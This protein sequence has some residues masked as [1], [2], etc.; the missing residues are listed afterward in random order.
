MMEVFMTILREDTAD[1][2][3]SFSNTLLETINNTPIVSNEFE[4]EQNWAIQN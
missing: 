4:F 1:T 2:N 3:Q